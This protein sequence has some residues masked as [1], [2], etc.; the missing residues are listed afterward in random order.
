MNSKKLGKMWSTML[1]TSYGSF[2]VGGRA[3]GLNT[4]IGERLANGLRR[5]SKLVTPTH[6]VAHWKFCAFCATPHNIWQE[7]TQIKDA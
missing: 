7:R 3:M 6:L 4:H 1:V 5:P 2:R